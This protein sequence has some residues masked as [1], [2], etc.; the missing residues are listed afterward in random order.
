MAVVITH[1]R[2][3]CIGCGAC[4]AVCSQYWRMADDGKADLMGANNDKLELAEA[5]CNM[6]AA[7]SCPVNVIHIEEN[8]EKKI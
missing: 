7:K 4:A 8:G 1:D 2:P 3:G 5:G 6:E